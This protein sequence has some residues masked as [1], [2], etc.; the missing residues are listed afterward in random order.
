MTEKEWVRQQIDRELSLAP[1]WRY[2]AL[3]FVVAL[4]VGS[5]ALIIYL[6]LK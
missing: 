6:L 5:Q 1:K 4:A 2:K 3:G